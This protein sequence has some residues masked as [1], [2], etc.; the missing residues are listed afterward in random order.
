MKDTNVLTAKA[1]SAL[2]WRVRTYVFWEVI[3]YI[4]FYQVQPIIESSLGLGIA[5]STLV[6]L[7]ACWDATKRS[8]IFLCRLPF[9]CILLEKLLTSMGF[10][11]YMHILD[12]S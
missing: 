10:Q 6:M 9:S 12:T 1:A 11:V 8:V 4:E 5:N 3:T 2:S 7:P